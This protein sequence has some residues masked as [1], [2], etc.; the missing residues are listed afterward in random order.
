M[1]KE[2]LK[3]MITYCLGR[4]IREMRIRSGRSQ[5]EIAVILNVPLSDL[6][7]CE[8][9]ILGL[10]LGGKDVVQLLKH[11]KPSFEDRLF[12]QSLSSLT[13]KDYYKKFKKKEKTEDYKD[14]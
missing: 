10:K 7:K 13:A 4:K 11:L 5:E 9:G 12:F 14:E 6:K 8:K 2:L 1:K 3:T